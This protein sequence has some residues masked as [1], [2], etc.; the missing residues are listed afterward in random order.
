MNNKNNKSLFLFLILSSIYSCSKNSCP[1]NSGSYSR[2]SRNLLP[3]NEIMLYDKINLI[4][5]EDSTQQISVEAGSNLLAGIQT[6]VENN[7]LTIKDQNHCGL[8]RDPADQTN[9]YISTNQLQKITYYG[10]GNIHSTNFL[11]A[12]E[13]TI[14]SWLGIGSINLSLKA[15]QTNA[16][17]RHNNA[18]ISLTGQSQSLYIYCADVGSVNLLDFASASVFIDSRSIK[19]I[20][21]NV[22]DSMNANILYKG[23]VYYKGNPSIIHSVIANSGRLI[24]LP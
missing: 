4:L 10:A 16:I 13:F 20:Y 17:I 1:F 7:I 9:V 8:L 6:G 22:S 21:V 11:Q 24:H 5:T 14:D 19:D 3:F 15:G 18:D 2:E 23:N 12:S